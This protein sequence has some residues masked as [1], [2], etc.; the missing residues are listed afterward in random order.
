MSLKSD[1]SGIMHNHHIMTD[2]HNTITVRFRLG[3]KGP[4]IKA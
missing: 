4:L 1:S 2:Q 3:T